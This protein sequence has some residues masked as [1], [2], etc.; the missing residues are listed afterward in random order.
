M[1]RQ[2]GKLGHHV[3]I[4]G[5]SE[6]K[7]KGA[8]EKLRGEK[9][10]AESLLMDV[11]DEKSILNAA[12]EFS[13]R[14]LKLDVLVNNAAIGLKG[15]TSILHSDETI[16]TETLNTNCFGPLCVCKAFLP[17]INS[18]GRIIN[19]SSGGGSM[20]D[21]VGG[22]SPVY[23]VSKSLLNAL[24]RHLA[25]ELETKNISVNAVCPGWVR[26]DMGGSTAPRSVAK[27]AETLV[28]LATDAPQKL[29]GKFFRDKEEIPW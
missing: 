28:W 27:G 11:S 20:T 23:C 10:E 17:F 16:L 9:V 8:L 5:R 1:A 2:L 26:T 29:S 7:V 13:K 14:N 15:D 22:W 4:S 18:P 25:Y 19:V 21:L 6:S 3:I 24:T 12:K